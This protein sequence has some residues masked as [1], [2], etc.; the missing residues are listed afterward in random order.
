MPTMAMSEGRG[1][2]GLG[3]GLDLRGVE[4]RRA[5]LADLAVQLG[6]RR[7]PLAE[8]GDLAEHVDPALVLLGLG[9][10]RPAAS[11]APS[12]RSTP[13]AATRSRPAFSAPARRGPPRPASPRRPAG[14]VASAND[15][16]N[17]DGPTRT[18]CPGPVSR[19]TVRRQRIASAWNR[20]TI[21]PV[22]TASSVNR[23]AVPTST[24]TFTP[25]RRQRRGD[26]GDGGR[27]SGVVDAR[28]RRG[29]GAPRPALPRVDDSEEH[30]DRLLP[31]H[32]A[33]PRPDVPAALAPFEDEPPGAVLEVLRR[34]GRA[35]GRGDRCE[36]PRL[37]ARA[38]GRAGPRRSGRTAAAPR[39][40]P[41][42]ARAAARAGR[43]RGRPRPRAGRPAASRRR[44]AARGPPAR[45]AS[46]GPGRA[47]R[48]RRRR[49]RRTRRVSLTRVIGPWTIG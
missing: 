30:R 18:S 34:A 33:R 28:R 25:R 47:G 21:A 6:D 42:P 8:R 5:P 24:P 48:R 22:A 20:G 35:R 26:R 36:S 27:R 45:G 15:S 41:R 32:E 16:T 13:L 37:R 17:G 23:Y 3:L 12:A 49:P 19:S 31:E 7:H 46:P 40:S 14:A 39:G 44:R 4:Q 11:P 9:D 1:R 29:R 38:P 2:R 43:T 10:R